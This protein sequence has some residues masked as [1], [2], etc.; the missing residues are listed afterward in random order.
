MRPG[1]GGQQALSVG[2][3]LLQLGLHPVVVAVANMVGK[4]RAAEVRQRTRVLRAVAGILQRQGAVRIGQRPQV[5]RCVAHIADGGNDALGNAALDGEVVVLRVG[6]GKRGRGAAQGQVGHIAGQPVGQDG[7][8]S[9]GQ[10]DPIRGA[11]GC[12][13]T[14]GGEVRIELEGIVLPQVGHV[15]GVLQSAVK[16]PIPGMDGDFGVRRIDNAETRPEVGLLRS[17]QVRIGVELQGDVVL[18]QQV[19]EGI[20]GLGKD[21]LHI[22]LDLRGELE[23]SRA[24]ANSG[25]HIQRGGPA[26]AVGGLVAAH[27]LIGLEVLPAQAR[28][29]GDLLGDTPVI[30][31]VGAVVPAGL[32]ADKL[33]GEDRAVLAV[34]QKIGRGEAGVGGIQVAGVLAGVVVVAA[35]RGWLLT[36]EAYAQK[37]YPGL[38]G[39]VADDLGDVVDDLVY[40]L[41]F[42]ARR[43]S[44]AAE[45][46]DVECAA[47]EPNLR[48]SA[49][50]IAGGDTAKPKTG[51]KACIRS[52]E[53]RPV[54]ADVVETHAKFVG[55]RVGKDVGLAEHEA[56]A[57]VAADV[58]AAGQNAK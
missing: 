14:A 17:N 30:L 48:Y 10:G 25:G 34:Q 32:A 26:H 7:G 15:T 44:A 45:V 8:K 54:R 24:A 46:G 52:I 11:G 38:Q 2:V 51:G 4:I 40:V 37:V 1:V 42:G 27:I 56:A 49:V 43:V 9:V 18:G 16:Q 50:H 19:W 57:D 31:Q 23:N 58:A 22:A 13:T 5:V 41:F 20:G 6:R 53:L 33:A 3:A 29:E 28:V 36:G 55:Q 35:R 47:A 39:V 12:G 21:G